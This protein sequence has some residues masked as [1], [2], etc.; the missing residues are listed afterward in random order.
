MCLTLAAAF[1]LPSFVGTP[2][3]MAQDAMPTPEAFFGFKSFV[4]IPEGKSIKTV[5]SQGADGKAITLPFEL[6]CEN[7]N[8]DYYESGTP[9]EYKS[10]LIVLDKFLISS[11]FVNL[12]LVS[13]GELSFKI[14]VVKTCICPRGPLCWS[15]MIILKE[16]YP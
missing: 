7:F 2:T 13:H 11:V 15:M 9:K 1:A 14:A 12:C 5:Y 6:F 10:D 8:V 4:M 3:A 16:A